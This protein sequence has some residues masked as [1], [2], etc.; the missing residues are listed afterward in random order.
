M[1]EKEYLS[2]TKSSA[3]KSNQGKIVNAHKL[4]T[5]ILLKLTKAG[6][7]LS[8]HSLQSLFQKHES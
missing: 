8:F 2:E 7:L 5:N 4:N 1:I 3:S 6:E